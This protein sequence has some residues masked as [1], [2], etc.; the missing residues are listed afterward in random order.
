MQCKE[1][2][3][4]GGNEMTNNTAIGTSQPTFKLEST[5][6]AYS[7]VH[8]GVWVL[9]DHLLM[10]PSRRGSQPVY[11]LCVVNC[12]KTR[13]DENYHESDIIP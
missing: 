2:P 8:H 10:Q 4:T 6:S 3:L 12:H 11:N 9:L 5:G 1:E 13:K 7:I